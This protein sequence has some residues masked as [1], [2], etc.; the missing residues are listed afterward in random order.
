MTDGG[1]QPIV[2]Q[3]R[4]ARKRADGEGSLYFDAKK[5][6]WVGSLQV[7]FKPDGRPD[8]FYHRAAGDSCPV[9]P[10]LERRSRR[11]SYLPVPIH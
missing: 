10:S 11:Q 3:G 1:I 9:A 8:R 6:L 7:G 5:K 4:R 2:A